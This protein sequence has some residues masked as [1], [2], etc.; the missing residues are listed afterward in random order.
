MR[1]YMSFLLFGGNFC[2]VNVLSNGG[3]RFLR[4][5]Q[6]ER[7]LFSGGGGSA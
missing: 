5:R 2:L 6:N 4:G 7:L 3:L 1:R